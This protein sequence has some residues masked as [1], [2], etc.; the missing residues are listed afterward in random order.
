V[1]GAVW[2]GRRLEL[3]SVV[4]FDMGGTS[5]DVSLV[6]DGTPALAFEREIDGIP[7]RVAGL[8]IHTIGAGGGSIAWRDSG[9]AL[10]VGPESAGAHPGPACYARGGGAATVT[11]ANLFLGRLGPSGLLGGSMPLDAGAAA[12]AIE[13]LAAT[14]ALSPLDTARGIIAVV[15]ANM[16]G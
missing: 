2:L 16:A 6:R 15:N 5:T 8:D 1:M 11:D 13:S 9:G 3:A 4:T 14:L 10:R 12:S 7:L